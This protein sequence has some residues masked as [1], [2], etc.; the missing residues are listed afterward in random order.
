MDSLQQNKNAI[1]SLLSESQNIGIVVSSNPSLDVMAAALSLHLILQDSGKNSQIVS[2]Q[3]PIVEHSTLVGI[4]QVIK[5]FG[6]LTKTLTV[7]FPYRE[8]EIEKVSYNIEGDKLNVNLFAEAQGIT[9][10]EKDVKFIRQGSSPQ[11]VFTVGVLN[12]AEL[13]GLVDVNLTTVVNLDNNITNSLFGNIVLVDAA[14]SSISEM[15]A[16]LAVDLSLQ[17]EFDVAQNLL[18]GITHA[19]HNFTSPT[20]APT[21][22]EMAGVLMQKGATRRA[23]QNARSVTDTSLSMLG[24]KSFGQGSSKPFQPTFD[25]SLGKQSK[26]F[27]QKNQNQ[28]FDQTQGKPKK[29]FDAPRMN[30]TQTTNQSRFQNQNQQVRPQFNGQNPVIPAPEDVFED[31]QTSNIT[32]D[33]DAPSDWLTPKIFKSTKDQQ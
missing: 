11:A 14:Y 10:E 26:P 12:P 20:A 23:M 5:Q 33:A 16:R 28:P 19:T 9:F 29:Q 32:A 25:N 15:V 27:G 31:M 2:K 1:V 24:G 22:F 13:D 3:D 18:D 21:A 17:V 30:V 4:D 7:S 8:G 6:G